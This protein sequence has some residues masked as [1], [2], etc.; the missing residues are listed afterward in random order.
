MLTYPNINPIALDIGVIKVRWY[1]LMYLVGL[2]GGWGL[3]A[4]RARDKSRGWTQHQLSDLIFYAA[5]G[6]VVGGRVGYMLF[7]DFPVLMQQPLSLFKVWQGGMS[8]HG[9]F[10]G[11]LISMLIFARRYHKNFVDIMDY[12][13]PVVP[14]GLG[15]GR[16]GNFINGELW[17]RVT[18]VPW[19]MIYPN[20]GPLPRHPSE[21]YECLL[22]GVMLLIILWCYSAKKPPPMAVSAVFLL[23]YGSFRFFCEFFRQPDPQLHFI[24][25]GWLTMGQ[26]LSFPM[27]VTGAVLWWYAYRKQKISQSPSMETK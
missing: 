22:E 5:I 24:A 27:V 9:G 4:L 3:L 19:A 2:L 23:G 8:F 7:Y 21:L 17:G 26:L 14:I 18:D 6:I 25:F 12:I 16:I 10:L 13:A 11:V 1:G 20:A 15:A